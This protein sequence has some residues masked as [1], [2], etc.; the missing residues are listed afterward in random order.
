VARIGF[1]SAGPS[2]RSLNERFGPSSNS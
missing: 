2:L 1:G